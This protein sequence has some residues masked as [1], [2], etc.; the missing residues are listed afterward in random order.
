VSRQIATSSTS[1]WSTGA[2]D[3]VDGRAQVPHPVGRGLGAAGRIRDGVA[4][5]GGRPTSPDW[6][7]RTSPPR[8]A[9][10]PAEPPGRGPEAEVRRR[11][12]VAAPL[13]ASRGGTPPR[14][15]VRTLSA[16][17]CRQQ[18]TRRKVAFC[19]S[20][21]ST[22]SPHAVSPE[23]RDRPDASASPSWCAPA[24]RERP[25]A[26]Q[27]YGDLPVLRLGAARAAGARRRPAL[28]RLGAHAGVDVSVAS[29]QLAALERAGYVERRPDPATAGPACSASPRRRRGP[30][31]RP[32][33]RSDWALGA[34]AGW[35][36]PTPGCSATF[37][38]G[39][40]PTWTAG[41][42]TA[43]AAAV[44]ARDDSPPRPSPLRRTV[45]STIRSAT[46]RRRRARR[47]RGRPR[48]RSRGR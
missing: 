30:R 33:L 25:A 14:S 6:P 32:A 3:P 40:S 44:P 26:A 46:T 2:A 12:P 48:R 17:R 23:T 22:R 10:A 43:G 13:P 4:G 47:R 37:S 11:R 24:A 5:P 38:T 39:S 15:A 36:E 8:R 19:K 42:R 18:P 35:D 21:S 1:A 16:S 7:R 41:S 28:Q 45:S 27:L 29:R 20:S 9:A 34:L 31:R